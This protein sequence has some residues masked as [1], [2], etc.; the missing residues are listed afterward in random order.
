M[1][2]LFLSVATISVVAMTLS[3]SARAD[4]RIV[5]SGFTDLDGNFIRENVTRDSEPVPPS[6]T[7]NRSI[8]SVHAGDPNG[9]FEYSASSDIGLLELKAYGKIDNTGQDGKSNI[10]IGILSAGARLDDVIM[11]ESAIADPYDVTFEL[12]VDGILDIAGG[13]AF[14]FASINF[15]P[16]NGLDSF[17]S[18]RYDTNGAFTDLLSVTKT[19]T[20]NVEAD[21][22]AFLSFSIAQIDPGAIITGQLNN[23]AT[24]RLI[25]PEGVSVA[26]SQSGTFGVVIPI[27]ATLPLFIG[28]LGLLGFIR[29]KQLVF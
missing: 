20:G 7:F 12:A 22:G 14:G 18:S 11:I 8:V 13:D 6:T 19:F 28:A 9:V 26:S 10:E 24:L 5:A 3:F 23:T 25:L 27:P 1:K 29:R 15:G 17:D 4:S 2:K 16:T 21:I